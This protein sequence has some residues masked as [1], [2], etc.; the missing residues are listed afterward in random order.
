MGDRGPP[1]NLSREVCWDLG[2]GVTAEASPAL[3]LLSPAAQV[4]LPSILLVR[5]K[6]LR[7]SG[8]IPW[9]NMQ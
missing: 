7:G 8:W 1:A 6:G 4:V 3:R 9:V 2:C 5:R